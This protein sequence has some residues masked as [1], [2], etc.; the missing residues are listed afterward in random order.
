MVLDDEAN[1]KEFYPVFPPDRSPAQVL[2]LLRRRI[3][4]RGAHFCGHFLDFGHLREALGDV[5]QDR[6]GRRHVLP[7]LAVDVS[8]DGV[9]RANGHASF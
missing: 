9:D 2:A 8:A 4:D 1:D 5:T 3:A 7:A 6:P